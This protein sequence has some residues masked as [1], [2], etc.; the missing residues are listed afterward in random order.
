MNDDIDKKSKHS[1]TSNG[2]TNHK[3]CTRVRHQK[4]KK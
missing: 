3:K 1:K 2:T 4:K